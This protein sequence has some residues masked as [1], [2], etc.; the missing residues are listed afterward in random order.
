MIH[1]NILECAGMGWMYFMVNL[2]KTPWR[3]RIPDLVASALYQ[4]VFPIQYFRYAMLHNNMTFKIPNQSVTTPHIYIHSGIFC[5]R[6]NFRCLKKEECL[7]INNSKIIKSH[8]NH[9]ITQKY[10]SMTLG[11]D[12]NQIIDHR[13]L[14]NEC[15]AEV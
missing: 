9:I 15:S 12:I 10:F 5:S 14:Q 7:V 3:V 13:H 2:V 8:Q 6:K 11:T 4:P 1:V